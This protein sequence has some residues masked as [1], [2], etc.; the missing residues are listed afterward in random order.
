MSLDTQLVLSLNGLTGVSPIFD[1]V[2]VFFASYLPFLLIALLVGVVFFKALPLR[3][4]IEILV[5]AGVSGLVA[6]YGV[7][8]LIR[9]FYHHPRPFVALDSIHPLFT[10]SSWSFPSG[11]ASFFFAMAT[12]IFLYDRKWGTFFLAAAVLVTLG[13]VVAGVHYP[14][15]ILG[16]AVLG[17]LVGWAAFA[18]T[19]HFSQKGDIATY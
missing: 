13:R 18:V 12:A 10:D 15:D 8:E 5:V 3:K 17:A 19:C 11:H 1:S 4:K 2:V 9:F 16:G 7:A 14:S 6:R